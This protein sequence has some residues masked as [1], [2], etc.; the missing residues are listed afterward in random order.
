V[1]LVQM[2]GAPGCDA[3]FT[4]CLPGASMRCRYYPAASYRAL[5]VSLIDELSTFSPACFLSRPR[6][7]MNEGVA[8]SKTRSGRC[9]DASMIDGVS[10]YARTY[11][12]LMIWL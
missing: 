4:R 3:S 11:T 10:A 6:C 1:A 8:S 12:S 7:R 2:K 9:P 5:M